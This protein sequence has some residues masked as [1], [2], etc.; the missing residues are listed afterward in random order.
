MT[1]AA[2]LAATAGDDW[3]ALDQQAQESY[4]RRAKAGE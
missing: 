3:T 1:R 4:Y 2:E